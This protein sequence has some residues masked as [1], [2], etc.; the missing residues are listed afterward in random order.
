MPD[1]LADDGNG[2]WN[3]KNKVWIAVKE[4]SYTHIVTS[5]YMNSLA[6][7]FKKMIFYYA[8]AGN[9]VEAATDFAVIRYYWTEGEPSRFACKPQSKRAK[10]FSVRRSGKW[11]PRK[12]AATVG[13]Y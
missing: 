1:L 7:G 10:R 5:Y 11:D 9:E 12:T 3:N 4:S 2:G 13:R 8:T 6:K